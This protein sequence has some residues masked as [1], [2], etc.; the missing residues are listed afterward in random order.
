[1]PS[2]QLLSFFRS[3]PRD[4]ILS[5]AR[6]SFTTRRHDYLRVTT[7]RFSVI[8]SGCCGKF[9][10]SGLGIYQRYSMSHRRNRTTACSGRANRRLF[11]NQG[12]CAPL[13]P[14][15]MPLRLIEVACLNKL[16]ADER[17]KEIYDRDGLRRVV[18]LRRESGTF[19]YQREHFSGHPAEMCWLP[20]RQL[21]VGIY[22]TA[23]RAENE[24]RAN[25][26]WLAG[27]SGA[28]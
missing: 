20:D 7:P 28:A 25:V 26:D 19:Y 23:E 11:I 22:E 2:V 13:M 21:P 14:S 8:F 17:L 6:G 18:I 5:T 4:V 1:M 12:S 24:A 16:M 27:T 3:I 9:V 10:A 15:V